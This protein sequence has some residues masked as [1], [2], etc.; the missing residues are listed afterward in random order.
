MNDECKDNYSSYS[1][2]NIQTRKKRNLEIII[3][4]NN[5]N[6]IEVNLQE[7]HDSKTQ[8]NFINNSNNSVPKKRKSAL[9]KE[10]IREI[11]EKNKKFKTLESEG[12]LINNED[13]NNTTQKKKVQKK[14]NRNLKLLNIIKERMSQEKNKDDLEQ[15]DNNNISGKEEIKYLEEIEQKIKDDVKSINDKIIKKDSEEKNNIEEEKKNKLLNII[16]SKKYNRFQRK[17]NEKEQKES[18]E[19]EIN[20]NI[21][22]NQKN[23]TSKQNNVVEPYFS[24]FKKDSR[25]NTFS[26]S[27]SKSK[28]NKKITPRK[29]DEEN[30]EEIPNLEINLEKEQFHEL[31]S[32]KKNIIPHNKR[33]KT[34]SSINDILNDEKNNSNNKENRNNSNSKEGALKI[35]ELLKMQKKGENKSMR[36]YTQDKS[37]INESK[38]EKHHKNKN[39][40]RN[41]DSF[42]YNLGEKYRRDK[43]IEIV[44]SLPKKNFR[45]EE[46]ESDIKYDSFNL[47]QQQFRNY[48]KLNNNNN[49]NKINISDNDIDSETKKF[50]NINHMSQKAIII[51]NNINNSFLNNSQNYPKFERV[52]N[53]NPISIR[54]KFRQKLK[55]FHTANENFNSIKTNIKYNNSNFVPQNFD[56]KKNVKTLDNSFDTKK[57]R[58]KPISKGLLNSNI[59]MK[60]NVYRPKKV[61]NNISPQKL[62]QNER[63]SVNTKNTMKGQRNNT[64]NNNINSYINNSNIVKKSSTAYIRKSPSKFEDNNSYSF[65]NNTIEHDSNY[66]NRTFFNKKP[67]KIINYIDKNNFNNNHNIIPVNPNNIYGMDF[68]SINGL[69]SSLETV[70]SNKVDSVN[71]DNSNYFNKSNISKSKGNKI[72]NIKSYRPQKKQNNNNSVIFNLEDLM[73]LEERLKEISYALDSGENIENKC[74]NFWNYYYNCSLYNL[75][76][77]IF[78]NKEDSNIVRLSINYELMSIMVCYEY[79]FEIELPEQVIYLLLELMDLNHDNLIVISEYILTKIVPENKQNIWVLKL[80]EI[81]KYSKFKDDKQI[82]NNNY[83]SPPIEKININTNSIIKILKNILL[84]FPTEYSDILVTLLKKIDTKTYEEINDFFREYIIRVQ[85]YEGSIM[86]SSFLKKNK[87]FKSLPAP[88]LISPPGK[89]YT[90]VLDLDET[91]VYFKIKSSKGGTLRARPYL[92]GFLEEMG[93]YYELIIW[94]SA[95]E[96]YANSLIDAIEYEKKYFDYVLYR[97]HA[98]II[99]DDFVKDLTRIGRSLDRIIIID[100]MPQNFRL[101]KENGINIKPFFGDDLDDSALY[102]LVPILKHIAESGKDVRFGL[103]K[104]K[105]EIVKKV[106]SNISRKNINNI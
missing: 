93:H 91:L 7:M 97:E 78:K 102:D 31:K 11:I 106:T 100:D 50:I 65:N 37:K 64:I 70:S 20:N 94:T 53:N 76:E 3:E 95:T 29:N 43:N 44:N 72:K 19:K 16:N 71:N 38:N 58:K 67:M 77:K 26:I 28:I 69:N 80:Q 99:G 105:E 27:N 66:K 4:E 75:L 55:N 21:N 8:P 104:Y 49:K 1:T 82:F 42:G 24:S 83:S 59:M 89:P 51:N 5:P 47:T 33:T 41:I 22:I 63:I 86:A 14:V 96:A 25:N 48:K 6:K 73:V 57:Q 35:V 88:Y 18:P 36:A 103:E 81:I 46:D 101:Q 61:I 12:E 39:S 92:F 85:N 45:D 90:L 23:Q 98:I 60:R 30:E 13:N 79:S 10:R 15:E 40:I 2:D 34:S 52:I 32:E 74:F 56:N 87:N 54:S 84:N 62:N 17:D 68:N 9:L